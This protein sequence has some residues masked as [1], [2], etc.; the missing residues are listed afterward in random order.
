[1]SNAYTGN[2]GLAMPASGDRT[3]NVPVNGNCNV[4]DA[5]APVGNLAVIPTEFPSASLNVHVAAGQFV[6]QDGSIGTFAG[7]T[8][9]AVTSSATQVL[10][11][12]GTAAWA[13]V[14]GAA[15]PA[16]P[17]VRL[18][19]VVTGA[20]TITSI[21]DNRQAFTVCGSV[22]DGVNLALGTATGTQLGTAATQK[23]GFYGATPIVQPAN[24][25]DLRT[26][27]INLG[28]L[29][30]G[31]ATPL[32]LN[33]GALAAGSAAI[34]DGGNVAVGTTTGTKIG[35]ATNQKLGFFNSTPV[36]QPTMGAATASGSWTSNEQGMLNTVWTLLRA[37]GLGS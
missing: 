13:L 6:R 26:A 9:Q 2:V 7:A 23:L 12:D 18:A 11:L 36:V 4:L 33:G 15:Y 32:N 21:A 14:V 34:A 28:L 20:G 35:T 1:M 17:H 22:A 19:T 31:G 29:A 27:L 37:L 25:T 3:W 30:S 5:L 10:Y 24:T 16:T 8:S